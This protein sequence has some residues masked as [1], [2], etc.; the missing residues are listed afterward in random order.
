MFGSVTCSLWEGESQYHT[1]VTLSHWRDSNPCPLVRQPSTQTTQPPMPQI[2]FFKLWKLYIFCNF[3]TKE[4][5]FTVLFTSIYSQMP[6]CLN[7]VVNK[8]LID[9]NVHHRVEPWSHIRQRRFE[10]PAPMGEVHSAAVAA[11]TLPPHARH[12]TCGWSYWNKIIQQH[13]VSDYYK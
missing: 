5:S 10:P 11:A 3:S 8:S 7:M 12:V 1:S 2:M 6:W 4:V 9:L 13:Y